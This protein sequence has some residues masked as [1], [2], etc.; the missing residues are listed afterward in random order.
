LAVRTNGFNFGFPNFVMRQ[1]EGGFSAA[2]G[3]FGSP[4]EIRISQ[5]VAITAATPVL[6]FDYVAVWEGA[7]FGG[8]VSPR[9]F[10]VKIE[11]IGGGAA[12]FSTNILNAPV[13]TSRTN[14][15]PAWGN[16]VDLTPFV[17]QDVRISLNT[18]I[19][20]FWAPGLFQLDNV[21]L[22]ASND[23][24]AITA[25]PSLQ[26][27]E[28]EPAFL[29]VSATGP[30]PLS[31]QWLRNG[32]SVPE[33]TNSTYTIERAARIDGADYSVIVSTGSM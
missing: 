2:F 21:A 1:I 5:E 25:P 4:G 13:E 23:V 29:K 30:E 3:L 22:R 11:P 32:V 31:Y 12:L 16:T 28:G 24:P 14:A 8:T 33:A 20:G 6:T 17:G 19:P 7:S 10:N 9:V 18:E 15:G 27:R 26:V